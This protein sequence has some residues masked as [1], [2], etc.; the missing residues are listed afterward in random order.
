MNRLVIDDF[1]AL[2]GIDWADRKHEICLQPMPGSKRTFQ[3]LEHRPEAIDEWANGLRERFGNRPIAVALEQ[4]KGPLI[5]ALSK[6]EHL[7]LVPI[8]PHLLA[9]LRRAFKPSGAK[10]DPSDAALAIDILQHHPE[11]LRPWRADDPRTRQLQRLVEARRKTV[12]QRVGATDRLL[13]NLKG[14]FPQALDCFDCLETVVA[15]DFLT[16]WPSLGHAKHAREQ[17]L[18]DFF[19]QHGVRGEERIGGRV[20]MLEEAMPLTRDSGVIVPALVVTRTLVAELRALIDGVEQ[21][22]AVIAKTFAAHPDAPIFASF[23]G[24]GPIFAPR[25]LAALGSDRERYDGVGAL[26]EYLGIAPVTTRSGKAQWIHWRLACPVFLR[27]SII[28][29][30]GMST[31]YSIW[32][33]AYYHQQREKGKRHHVAVRALAFKWL[34]ILYRCWMER[35]P[36]DE[37]KYLFALKRRGSPLLRFITEPLPIAA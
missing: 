34:R 7:V 9:G 6:Y 2:V 11:K 35:T 8:N 24:A 22:D 28:E 23:P 12:D 21:Y 33:N 37:A 25:L 26:Q 29:W 30:A 15:C 3:V 5:N 32:A 1:A 18:R 31:R 16:R 14:Y 19:H 13:A 20:A 10:D 4:R 17:A 27:Q 36:Y